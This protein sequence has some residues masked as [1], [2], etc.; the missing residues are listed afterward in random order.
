MTENIVNPGAAFEQRPDNKLWIFYEKSGG[1]R[2]RK[3]YVFAYTWYDA[4][5]G[6][7]TALA[8]LKSKDVEGS[9]VDLPEDILIDTGSMLVFTDKSGRFEVLETLQ[10]MSGKEASRLCVLPKSDTL[11]VESDALL[12]KSP[13]EDSELF[14][15]IREKLEQTKPVPRREPG[16][17][18]SQESF[19]VSPTTEVPKGGEPAYDGTGPA[20]VGTSRVAHDDS[21]EVSVDLEPSV[22]GSEDEDDSVEL[23]S[24]PCSSEI[25]LREMQT[26]LPW[27]IR[28][29][30]D[31]RANPQT[32]K[33]FAHALV[34][35]IKATGKLSALVDDMD[36][37]REI[38]D[39]PTL[40]DRYAKY[41]ADLVVCALRIANEF[42]G[43]HI[44]LQNAVVDRIESKNSGSA[45]APDTSAPE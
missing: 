31:F 27:T 18:L 28:Y 5:N 6:A 4:R 7:L 37:D 15:S 2:L 25:S 23:D 3:V 20:S 42:P 8:P 36:H 45:G 40:R 24:E 1:L 30:R 32:H 44:D 13:A 41:V 38:A 16:S 14:N 21:V 17:V 33:D 43:G 11:P 26:T 10:R 29:S 19:A 22:D 9:E 39:D 12:V 35:V 34:H